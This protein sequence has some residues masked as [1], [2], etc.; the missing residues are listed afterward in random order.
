[1]SDILTSLG[2]GETDFYA[3]IIK[4]N[5]DDRILVFNDDVSDC[6]IENYILYILKWNREDKDLP[7][8]KRK[9]ITIYINSPGGD[10]ISGFNMVNVILASATPI[11]GIVFGMA[12]SMGYHIFLACHERY[13]FKDSI[14]LQHDGQ[15]RISNSTSKAKDT[16]KFFENM[17]ERTKAYVLSRTNMDEEFY[18]AHYDQEYYMYANEEAKR[19][20][21]VDYIIGE[22]C[23]LDDIL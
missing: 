13:A 11:K 5:L 17:E 3:E 16:M 15:I 20:G 2:I 9:P 8:E 1:M 14:L 23:N 4:E 12:A 19:L 6:V 22:D 21:C 7:V 10:A 18:D